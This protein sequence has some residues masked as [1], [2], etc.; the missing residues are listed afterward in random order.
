MTT[1]EFDSPINSRMNR[2]RGTSPHRDYPPLRWC[3][4]RDKHNE[5]T[6]TNLVIY[7]DITVSAV[8]TDELCVDYSDGSIVLSTFGGVGAG[9]IE[10]VTRSVFGTALSSTMV[11]SSVFCNGGVCKLFFNPWRANKICFSPTKKPEVAEG[12]YGEEMS[13]RRERET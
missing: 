13:P 5:K 9:G 6:S 2:P 7:Q 8:I 4:R 3:G 1:L 12:R 10:G 11:E